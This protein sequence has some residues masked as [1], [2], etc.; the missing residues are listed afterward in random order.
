LLLPQAELTLILLCQSAVNP[1]ISASGPFNFNKT[2]LGPVG[3]RIL[4]HTP[5][6]PHA[7]LGTI[8]PKKAFILDLPSTP[9]VASRSSRWI[10]KAKS[11]PI[12]LNSGMPTVQSRHPR[13]KIESPRDSAASW[14]HSRIP[15]PLPPYPSSKHSPIS[16]MCLSHDASRPLHCQV[17][18]ADRCP[19]VQGW[20]F[21]T[22]L[23]P[24]ASLCHE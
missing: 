1:K 3:C 9:F 6:Q 21:R 11:F 18:P 8:E 12:R 24:L 14:M 23:L 4:I 10:L 2:P 13:L 19:A 15:R 16:G 20:S 7:A 5:S 22:L 17:V